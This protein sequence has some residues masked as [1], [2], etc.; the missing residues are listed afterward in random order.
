M[1][2]RAKSASMTRD[3]K[4]AMMAFREA[5]L[6][7]VCFWRKFKFQSAFGGPYRHRG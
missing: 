7:G 3:C 6:K 5:E 2:S 4:S 1:K